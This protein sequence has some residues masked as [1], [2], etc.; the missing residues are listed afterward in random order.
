MHELIMALLILEKYFD[1]GSP[2]QCEHDI[3]YVHVDFADVPEAEQ[4]QL[5]KY[6]FSENDLGTFSSYKYGSS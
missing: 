5:E 1:G 3:L 2:L 4:I 6:G